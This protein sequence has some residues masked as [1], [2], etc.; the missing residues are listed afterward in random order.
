M[1]IA[2][3][4]SLFVVL[5]ALPAYLLGCAAS[6]MRNSTGVAGASGAAG[7]SGVA[8]TSGTSGVA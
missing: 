8:G 2:L 3:R 7:A 6:P 5:A 1:K 4:S